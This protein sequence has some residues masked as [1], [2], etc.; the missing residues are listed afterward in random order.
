MTDRNENMAPR[1][2]IKATAQAAIHLGLDEAVIKGDG[3]EA[4]ITRDGIVIGRVYLGAINEFE[5][6]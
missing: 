6:P 4:L 2:D 1:H 5:T 3:Y